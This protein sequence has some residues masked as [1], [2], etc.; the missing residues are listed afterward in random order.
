M[1]GCA[2]CQNIVPTFLY[3][4]CLYSEYGANRLTDKRILYFRFP[5]AM[6]CREMRNDRILLVELADDKLDL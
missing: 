3:P 4:K 6:C 1:N 5:R 2:P